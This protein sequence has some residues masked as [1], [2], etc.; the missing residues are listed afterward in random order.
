[1]A[2]I[3]NAWVATAFETE[4]GWMAALGRGAVLR[5][6]TIAHASPSRALAALDHDQI[7]AED[8]VLHI[9]RWNPKLIA[10]VQA[11]AEGAMDDFLDVEIDPL[12]RGEF[13]L[14]V[15]D[16]CRRIPWGQTVSYG[17]LAQRAKAP[18][19]AR[20]VGTVMASN[21]VSLIVP[22][23]RVIK[24]DGRV[25]G[26]GSPAGIDLKKR[27]LALEAQAARPKRGKSRRKASRC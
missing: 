4:L 20:A 17:E 27:L 6:L 3:A 15:I 23:H 10:R 11:F 7:A 16:C 13:A 19:A 18:R 5:Q 2:G 1:M 12:D 24:S 26:Y 22:C 9:G 8:G 21:C 14:R 25:G